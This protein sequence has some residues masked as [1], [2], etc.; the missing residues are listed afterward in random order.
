MLGI[1]GDGW[2]GAGGPV[3]AVA[4]W[5]EVGEVRHTFTHFHLILRVMVAPVTG[6]VIRGEWL[7]RK[8]FRPGDLPTVMRKA[9]DLA[10]DRLTG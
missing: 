2:D 7:A 8:A 9:W 5:Q 1:P 3:P 10:R 6:P 4:D